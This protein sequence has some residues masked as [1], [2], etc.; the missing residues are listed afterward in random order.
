MTIDGGGVG[1]DREE[2]DVLDYS[3]PLIK[4]F[5]FLFEWRNRSAVL[6]VC[7]EH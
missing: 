3:T 2:M 5:V 7:C 1:C 6:V 4:W